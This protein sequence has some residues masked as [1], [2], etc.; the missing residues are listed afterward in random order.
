MKSTVSLVKSK[1]HYKGTTKSLAQIKDDIIDSIS[2]IS[3]LVI[4]INLVVTKTKAYPK[5]VEL[6]VTPLDAVK[7]FIDFI[8]PFYDKEIIITERS[9]WG[10]TKE[11]FELHGFTKLAEEHSQVKL[12]DLKEDEIIE[13]T[14][15]YP[16]GK[17]VLPFSKTMMQTPFLVSIVRPKTHCSVVMTAGIKNVLVGAINCSWQCRLQIHKGNYIHNILT[18]I[19]NLIYPN[20]AIIDGTNGMEGNGPIMG[21]KIKSG[22]SLASFDPLAADTLAAKLMGFNV[23]VIA[24]K[25]LFFEELILVEAKV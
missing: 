11:G 16:E 22:W 12:L 15:K 3:S 25:K 4:K 5:G 9:A 17:L 23:R 21:R 10:K 1:E 14:I 19:A 7:S 13:K 18:S 6:A 8:L 24:K 20:L 2:G